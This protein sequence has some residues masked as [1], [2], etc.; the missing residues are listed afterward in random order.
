MI[1][2]FKIILGSMVG[3]ELANY[4]MAYGA[5][6]TLAQN[7]EKMARPL[8]EVAPDSSEADDL[9]YHLRRIDDELS[10]LAY[11]GIVPSLPSRDRAPNFVSWCLG[12]L[13]ILIVVLL[14]FWL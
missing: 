13:G 4:D 10:R 6:R 12:F 2:L 7:R 9:K 3:A 14:L 5:A 1:G 11:Y 8:S